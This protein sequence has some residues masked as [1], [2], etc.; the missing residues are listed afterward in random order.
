M[1]NISDYTGLR[2]ISDFDFNGSEIDCIS[3][4]WDYYYKKIV[5]HENQEL[6]ISFLLIKLMN[7]LK[8]TNNKVL[9]TKALLITISFF[10][11]TPADF[12]DNRG[13]EIELLPSKYRK[14]AIS[15]LRQ[16]FLLN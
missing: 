12:H 3:R 14:R 10:S 11:H 7:V 16:E 13:I 5:D 9:I 6:P 1:T 15:L 2:V 8:E 4:I